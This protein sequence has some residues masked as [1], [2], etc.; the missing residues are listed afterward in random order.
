MPNCIAEFEHG[1]HFNFV[2][3][4]KMPLRALLLPNMTCNWHVLEHLCINILY[5]LKEHVSS[6][7]EVDPSWFDGVNDVFWF[8]EC[9]KE[10]QEV[11][12]VQHLF[13]DHF[14]LVCLRLLNM[15]DS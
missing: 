12:I 5:Q 3:K 6:G 10:G 2:P 4:Q 7:P 1:P 14:A 13:P 11:D 15:L 9:E 8:V